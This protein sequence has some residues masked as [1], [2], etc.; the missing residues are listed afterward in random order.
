MPDYEAQ[1]RKMLERNRLPF[2]KK[3]TEEDVVELSKQLRGFANFKNNVEVACFEAP[4]ITQE[5][6]DKILDDLNSN[7]GSLL[8]QFESK[9]LRE[10]I[11]DE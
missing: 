11:R 6:I 1:A 8:K 9:P 2:H 3:Y 7:P 5:R 10:I 4:P